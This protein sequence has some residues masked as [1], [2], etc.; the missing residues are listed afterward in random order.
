[1]AD[2]VPPER[3]VVGHAYRF[4]YFGVPQH[5]LGV[6][7]FVSPHPSPGF[8]RFHLPGAEFNSV[9]SHHY[10]FHPDTDIR[11]Q[12][13][14]E[15][16]GRQGVGNLPAELLAEIGSFTKAPDPGRIYRDSSKNTGVSLPRAG[17]RRTRSKRRRTRRRYRNM[18]PTS[19]GS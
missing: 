15:Q 13:A 11:P 16:M 1:M 3:L 6:M 4:K 5:H 19:V 10:T 2:A 9:V 12:L 8:S 17:R 18:L 7:N 14:L